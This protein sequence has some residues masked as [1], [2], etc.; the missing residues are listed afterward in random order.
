MKKLLTHLSILSISLC[1][2]GSSQVLA[3]KSRTAIDYSARLVDLDKKI[4][5]VISD[6]NLPGL[7]I[8]VVA[9]GQIIKAKGYG[10]RDISKALLST[11]DTQYSIGSSTKAFT[12]FMLAT[13]VDEG[14]LEWDVAVKDYLPQ[15]DMH[16]EY[17]TNHVTLRDMLSHRTGLPRHELIW[18]ANSNLTIDDL[19]V[20]LPNL[21]SSKELRQG[22]QYS[23]LMYAMSGYLA[24]KIT[25]QDWNE[26]IQARILDKLDMHNTSLNYS[27]MQSSDD[28][29]LPYEEDGQELKVTPF[30]KHIN[31]VM[32]PAGVINSSVK[33][34]SKW[35]QVLLD[36]GLYKGRQLIQKPSLAQL[37]SPH[38]AITGLS[39]DADKSPLSYGL[40]WFTRTYRGHYQV[41]HGGNIDGY[42]SA[43][44]TYPHDGIGI[45]VLT[46]KNYSPVPY[47]L[48]MDISD[49]L[50]SLEARNHLVT[51]LTRKQAQT[52]QN[53]A[54]DSEQDTVNKLKPTFE[55][56]EY[57]GTYYHPGYGEL[58]I[59]VVEGGLKV[60]YMEIEEQFEH[61]VFNTFVSRNTFQFGIFEDEKLSFNINKNGTVAAVNLPFEHTLDG[62]TFT[63]QPDSQ[64]TNEQYLNQFSG[65]FKYKSMEISIIKRANTLFINIPGQGEYSLTPEAAHKFSVKGLSGFKLEFEVGDSV[66]KLTLVQPSGSFVADRVL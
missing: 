58:N 25:E 56:P 52:E 23:N 2:L 14:K 37:Q 20:K 27:H 61:D 66:Q 41:Q 10:Y 4:E 3:A 31:G 17:A 44:F 7:A 45:V 33:D 62:I 15:W 55:L 22:F 34:M 11:E 50:F 32:R 28:Y 51:S 54:P 30:N 12:S 35:L 48:A 46:N 39:P 38:I 26:L 6:F 18:Y 59:S 63:R 5:K 65:E 16:D 42:T 47:S 57:T 40:G 19:M 29:S 24:E 9:D 8:A 60:N 21:E 64:Y 53:N 43:V 13:L 49:S 36:E 1:M